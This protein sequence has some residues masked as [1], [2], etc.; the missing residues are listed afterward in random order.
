MKGY[1]EATN[2]LKD[3]ERALSLGKSAATET[4]LRKLQAIMR[5]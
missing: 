5:E 4:A 3:L 1:H 2:H